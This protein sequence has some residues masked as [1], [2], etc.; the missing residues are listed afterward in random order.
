[1][2]DCRRGP[3]PA[4]LA[5]LAL[6]LSACSGGEKRPPVVVIGADGLE[7]SVAEPLLAAGKMPNLQRLLDEGVG[8]TLET[9]VPTFSPALWTTIA[10]GREPL[11][12]G[13]PY[14]SEMGPDGR[15]LPGGLPYT[16]ESRRVPA[17][18]NLAD[19]AGKSVT[20]VAWWVSW[21]AEHLRHGR[22]VASYAAQAQGA[23]M[24]KAGVWKDGLPELTWPESLAESIAPRLRE[25]GPEGANL[26]EQIRRFGLFPVNTLAKPDERRW[27]NLCQT[28]LLMSLTGDRTHQRIFCDLLEQEVS[29][30]NLVYFGATDVVGHLFWKYQ[31]PGAYPWEVPLDQ[32]AAFGQHVRK[33]YEQLD[34]WL[35]EILAKLPAERI[36]ILM[37]D[38]GMRAYPLPNPYER[39][40]DHQ[41]GEPGIFVISGTGVQRR[42]L[43]P[44]ESRRLGH[45]L[46]VAP[47]LCDLLGIEAQTVL[48]P[49]A[50][51]ASMSPEWQAAH[52]EPP[53]VPARAYRAPQKPR[54]PNAR[55]NE[56]YNQMLNEIGYGE[57][58]GPPPEP[59]KPAPPPDQ[60]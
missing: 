28:N 8:G 41:A 4:L 7:W 29:D 13:I 59:A 31:E 30:L 53:R 42:G 46:E 51:R 54:Q 36:V 21:P 60:Q 19:A 10:T 5:V 11:D 55:V 39:S 45:I 52:P 14:F 24:W 15:P 57:V 16:S 33:T 40:G 50:L 3:I 26:D 12:H 27:V 32:Q 23:V 1:M 44:R 22:I 56:I 20:S 35:G 17:I 9:M 38:H 48:Q 43:L 6:A 47:L 25:G 34:L 2:P 18:W 49:D 58:G 37:A